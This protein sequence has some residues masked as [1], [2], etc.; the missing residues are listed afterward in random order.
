[1]PNFAFPWTGDHWYA[2]EFSVQARF[3]S[4]GFRD[5]ERTEGKP[6]GVRRVAL[7]GDSFVLALQVPFEHTAGQVLERRLNAE[8]RPPGVL[9]WEV[10]NLGISAYGLGQCL[11]AWERHASRFQPDYVVLFVGGVHFHRT[12]NAFY[13]ANASPQVKPVWLS[14]RPTF[15]VEQGVLVRQ[16]PADLDALARAQKRLIEEDLGGSRIARYPA[17]PFLPDLLRDLWWSRTGP[18]TGR[19]LARDGTRGA[20]QNFLDGKTLRTNLKVIDVLRRAVEAQGAR[21]LLADV[22]LFL[23]PDA[24]RLPALLQDLCR[25]TDTGYLPLSDNLAAAA[26][27]GKRVRWVYDSHFNE[28]GNRV[29][30]DAVYRWIAGRPPS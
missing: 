12:T 27:R 28:A 1:V 5:L 21:L 25:R 16:P 20:E 24:T 14:V 7:L 30:A 29:F 8:L 2:K 6:P 19:I 9:R 15:Q 26:R 17:R 11:I 23:E 22:S 3:N 4:R 10:L 13:A 18:G